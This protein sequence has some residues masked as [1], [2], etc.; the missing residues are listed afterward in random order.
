MAHAGLWTVGRTPRWPPA[1]PWVSRSPPTA[2][3]TREQVGAWLR[4]LAS[5]APDSES[6]RQK[7]LMGEEGMRSSRQE[8]A[9]AEGLQ[10][11]TRPRWRG[12]CQTPC[13]G[14]VS[15]AAAPARLWPHADSLIREDECGTGP[16]R[17]TGSLSR[18]VTPG[19]GGLEPRPWVSLG[20]RVDCA[21]EPIAPGR[22]SWRR[23]LRLTRRTARSWAGS[24][25]RGAAGEGPQV[26][27][28]G[29]LGQV[30]RRRGPGGVGGAAAAPAAPHPGVEAPTPWQ[31]LGTPWSL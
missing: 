19:S 27:A 24:D 11:G 20:C 26:R 6:L 21:A 31:G 18:G 29:M 30:L 17:S 7:P 9:G 15:A 23:W 3:R 13:V 14:V 4:A 1:R 28:V 8:G 5:F 12:R 25:G 2:T 10:E 22:G 16:G